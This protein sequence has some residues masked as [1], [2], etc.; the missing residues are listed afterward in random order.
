M[1]KEPLF[2]GMDLGTFKTSVASSS[3][4]REVLYTAV[5][6]PRD[7]VARNLLGRD[8]VF[9]KEIFEHRLALHV[10][11]PFE[12]GVLKYLGHDEAGVPEHEVEKHLEAARLL[13]THAVA[14]TEPPS[15]APVFGVIGAPS[16]AST[17]NKQYLIEASEGAFDAVVIVSEPFAVAYG[18]GCVSDTLVVDIGAGTVDICPMCGVYPAEADQETLS[19][20]GDFIDEDFLERLREA[21]P[22]ARMSLN[23]AREVKEKYA[24]VHDINEKVVLSLPTTGK[25]KQFDVT[26]LLKDACKKMARPIVTGIQ[27]VV[28]KYD[29]EF[30]HRLL[31][32]ILLC[33]GGS[34]LKG[35]DLFIEEHLKEYGGAK[36]TR[37][38]DSVFAGAFGALKLAMNMRAEHWQEIMYRAGARAAA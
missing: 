26:F 1:A 28:A 23:M 3:G 33:G 15:G 5:G 8:V 9:G 19:V 30:Q 27:R 25:L 34:Q 20:G 14:L 31:G 21:Y 24:F 12:K 6:R 36:V 7:H 18:M 38:A 10:V 11:R 16:R 32:N 22:E 37:V 4:K 2:I 29:P 13:V 35:L 17:V